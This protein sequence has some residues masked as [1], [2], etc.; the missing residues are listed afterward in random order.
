MTTQEMITKATALITAKSFYNYDSK[1]LEA[2]IE[3][4]LVAGDKCSNGHQVVE[5]LGGNQIRRTTIDTGAAVEMTL[6]DAQKEGLL[7]TVASQQAQRSI[8]V[9][10]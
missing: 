2:K 4:G 5:F 7:I 8:K 10:V 6:T 1:V 3:Q 9:G